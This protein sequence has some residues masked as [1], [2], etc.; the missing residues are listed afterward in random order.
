M[1]FE[2][3]S[4]PIFKAV[5]LT[6]LPAKPFSGPKTAT[7]DV[8]LTSFAGNLSQPL[9]KILITMCKIDAREG[10]ASL[11]TIGAAVLEIY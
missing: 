9:E 11:V 8:T 1:F 6:A 7:H 5:V 2:R 10:T 3:F 4:V